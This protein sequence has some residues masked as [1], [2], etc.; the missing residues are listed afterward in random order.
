MKTIEECE[1]L[2]ESVGLATILPAK[3]ALLP[4]L[5]WEARGDRERREVWD[6]AMERVWTWKDDLPARKT[7]WLGQLFGDRVVLLHR[8]LLPPFLAWRDQ[9]R[10]KKLY[11]DGLLTHE[12]FRV[13][14]AVEQATEPLGRKSLR[15]ASGLSSREDAGRF[16]RACRDLERR[17]LL[18]RAGRSSTASGW[19]ANSYALV[20]AWFPTEWEA[21]RSWT[22]EEARAAVKEALEQAAPG[23]SER[24]LARWMR[25]L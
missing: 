9:P 14:T 8:R 4:C 20:E 7:A 6:E 1:A 19:D 13:V 23:A 5:L 11:E 22:N 25:N 2:L 21:A 12:A 3:D 17:L 15:R 10:V 16:D 18:T 24:Q